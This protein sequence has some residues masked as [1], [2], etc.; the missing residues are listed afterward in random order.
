MVILKLEHTWPL[1]ICENSNRFLIILIYMATA[2]HSCVLPQVRE[3]EFPLRRTEPV[4]NSG[5]T[6]A[7]QLSDGLKKAVI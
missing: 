1:I 3:F 4:W 6:V 7:Y 5:C 2:Y